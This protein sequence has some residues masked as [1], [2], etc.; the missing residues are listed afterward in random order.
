MAT[1]SLSFR[2]TPAAQ[3]P[4]AQLLC[5]HAAGGTSAQ[6]LPW[7]LWLPEDTLLITPT[8]PRSD[9]VAGRTIDG[10]AWLIAQDA[11]LRP[12]LPLVVF[13]HSLGALVALRVVR[14]LARGS[15][16]PVHHLIVAAASDPLIKPP[17]WSDSVDDDD[18][19]EHMRRRY[20]G[21]AGLDLAGHFFPAEASEPFRQVIRDILHQAVQQRRM[22]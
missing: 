17:A 11:P 5:L 12:N 2:E 14:H 16:P 18:L 10:V 9:A 13:G 19:L 4:S 7:T 1:T 22:L 6:F 15:T 21:F 20:G 8:L 3:Q